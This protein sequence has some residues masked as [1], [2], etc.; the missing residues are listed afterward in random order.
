MTLL[1]LGVNHKTAAVALREKMSFLPDSFEQA[2]HHLI[3]TTLVKSGVFLSTCNRTEFY[4]S[5]QNQ[6]GLE[7]K[8]IQWLCEYFHLKPEELIKSL[9]WYY[10]DQAVEHL[11]RVASGLDSLILGEPQILGQIKKAFTQ[12][13]PHQIMCRDLK[14]LFQKS[15]SVAKRVRTE[16]DIGVH[17]V[18]F[19]FAACSLALQIFESLS[20]VTVLLIGAG[21]T[22]ELMARHLF[23][24]KVKRL[25]IANR[26]FEKALCLGNDFGADVIRFEEIPSRLYEADITMSSTASQ[27]PVI[28]KNMIKQALKKRRNQP[29]LFIDIAVPRDIEP[30]VGHVPNVYLYNIDDLQSII[31]RHLSHR[32]RAVFKA[33]S[34][35]KEESLNFISWVRS[36]SSSEMIRE[37]RSKADQIRIAL[38]EKALAAIKK[39]DNLEKTLYALTHKLTN[40]LIHAPTSSLKKAALDGDIERFK[41]LHESLEHSG[42][43]HFKKQATKKRHPN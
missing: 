19:A 8:L 36:Q 41:F 15:F 29:M 43:L 4:L 23:K 18:S 7:K 14:R 37:Y 13:Q 21:E 26:T 24:H 35:I 33:E 31:E 2:F 10:D 17:A 12:S 16:T 32:K 11:M 42:L 3:Q 30:E 27:L 9:Y 1:A 5:A 38:T 39:G 28:D 25:I 40:Q 6:S 20:E 22:I 34:I